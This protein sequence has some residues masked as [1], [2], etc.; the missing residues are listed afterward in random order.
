MSLVLDALQ[1]FTRIQWPT[2]KY[3]IGVKFVGSGGAT[4]SGDAHTFPINAPVAFGRYPAYPTGGGAI[5]FVESTDDAKEFFSKQ[6]LKKS[7]FQSDK[8]MVAF[9]IDGTTFWYFAQVPASAVKVEIP[10]DMSICFQYG[11]GTIQAS[12]RLL[13]KPPKSEHGEDPNKFYT[14]K[15]ITTAKADD[16]DKPPISTASSNRPNKFTLTLR[17]SQNKPLDPP[18]K[19]WGG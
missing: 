4:G 10:I 2:G 7:S 19:S 14:Y 3:I 16:E 6:D 1:R 8:S 9:F 18:T 12:Y 11:K 17:N 13:K 15:D 5:K